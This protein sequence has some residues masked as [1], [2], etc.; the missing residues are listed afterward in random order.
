MIVPAA[1][2]GVLIGLLLWFIT[3]FIIRSVKGLSHAR[4]YMIVPAAVGGVLIGLLLWFIT[5]FTI[6]EKGLSLTR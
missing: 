1:V 2:G 6:L 4:V 3:I 5:I